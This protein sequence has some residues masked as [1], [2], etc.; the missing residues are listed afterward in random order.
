MLSSEP[1]QS[2]LRSFT[3]CRDVCKKFTTASQRFSLTFISQWREAL[4]RY[5]VYTRCNRLPNQL[6][7][8]G[9][10]PIG[11]TNYACRLLQPFVSCYSATFLRL[12]S[13]FDT[14]RYYEAQHMPSQLCPNPASLSNVRAMPKRLSISSNHLHHTAI[15]VSQRPNIVVK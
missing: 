5:I 7:G 12:N 10:E 14:R 8:H 2:G 1:C 3:I 13:C 4:K 9:A 6:H 15:G 11:C